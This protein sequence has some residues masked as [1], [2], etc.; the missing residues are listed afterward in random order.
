VRDQTCDAERPEQELSA[1]WLIDRGVKAIEAEDIG[2]RLDALEEHF[3]PA[4][5]PAFARNGVAAR[6]LP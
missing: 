4:G 3:G 5:A 6:T 1:I 2:R